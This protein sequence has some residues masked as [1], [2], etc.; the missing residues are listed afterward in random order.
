MMA[1]LIPQMN[2]AC[3]S[4]LWFLYHEM[5]AS[6]YTHRDSTSAS[7]RKHWSSKTVTASF[8][9]KCTVEHTSTMICEISLSIHEYR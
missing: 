1:K 6:G 3:S 2:G 4:S 9:T 7:S 8:Y 5:T